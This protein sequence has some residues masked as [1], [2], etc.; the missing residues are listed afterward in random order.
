MWRSAMRL[1]TER[2]YDSVTVEEI[3]DVCELSPRTFF[4][5]F[6]SK[7]DVL[8]A[9]TDARRE[10]LLDMLDAQP[11]G[12]TPFEVLHGA[13]RSFAAHYEP[14]RAQYRTRARIIESA[15]SLQSR[16]SEFTRQWD[17]DVADFFRGS[18]RANLISEMDLRLVVGASMTAIRV[19]IEQWIESDEDLLALVDAAFERL[20]AGLAF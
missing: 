15:S 3:A 11:P 4:R 1:F 18:G 14:E 20:G 19:S 2:G 6:G 7:E 10:L 16:N 9:G 13:S 17:R 12:A 5:Y 8:F